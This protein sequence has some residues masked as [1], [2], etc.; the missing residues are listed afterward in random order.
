[1]A[2]KLPCRATCELYILGENTAGLSGYVK[3]TIGPGRLSKRA[4]EPLGRAGLKWHEQPVPVLELG[5][6][7]PPRLEGD[8]K[9][10][11]HVKE[12]NKMDMNRMRRLSRCLI[13]P[14]M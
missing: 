12:R 14:R 4:S 8:F 10:S 13:F 9:P 6:T 2:S 1:M 11:L 7:P 5:E 3:I